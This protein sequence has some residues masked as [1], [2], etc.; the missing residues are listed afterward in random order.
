MYIYIYI[1]THIRIH[2]HTHIYIYVYTYTYTH[3]YIYIHM[4]IY[5]HKYIHQN[6]NSLHKQLSGDKIRKVVK[7]LEVTKSTY[8]PAFNRLCKEVAQVCVCVCLCVCEREREEKNLVREKETEC[9]CVCVLQFTNSPCFQPP[10][11][12][13]S[14]CLW[15]CV[16]VCLFV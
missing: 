13:G 3:I 10:L 5:T 8:F 12:R 14:T 6:L 7:V 1:Q 16:R 4:C 15:V 9:A 2:I 11:Q